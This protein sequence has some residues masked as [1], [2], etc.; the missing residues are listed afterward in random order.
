MTNSPDPVPTW[1]RWLMPSM[2]D[3]LFLLLLVWLLGSYGPGL[4]RD[5]DTG[6]HI[7]TGEYI[8]HHLTI[9]KEDLFSYTNE[10]QPWIVQSWLSAVL[11]ALMHRWLGLG[12]VVL[13]SA[14][15]ISFTFVLLLRLLLRR[16]V[17]FLTAVILVVL[18]A[19]A[20]LFSWNARPQI[21]TTLMALIW[22][23][24]LDQYTRDG[25]SGRLIFLPVLFCW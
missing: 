6:M 25:R 17:D 1:A 8:L 23:G 19:S 16:E 13:L 24:C 10:G 4:M 3:L 14:I 21:F 9:P 12:G 18:A 2:E 20:S 5:A 15:V 7:R 22:Y 11:F